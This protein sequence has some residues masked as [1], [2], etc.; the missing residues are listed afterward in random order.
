MTD[1]GDQQTKWNARYAA[2]AMQILPQ[3]ADVLLDFQH[4]LP[5][6]GVALDLACGLGGNALFLAQKGMQTHAWDFSSVAIEKLTS[7][8]ASRQVLIHAL[9]RDVVNQPPAAQDYDVIAVSRFLHRPL[10]AKIVAAL[11][12]S[13]LVFYQTF[14]QDKTS[15]IG[16]SNPEYLLAENEL[17]KLFSELRILDYREEGLVGN[18]AHGFRH[19]AMLVGQKKAK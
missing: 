6:T 16:P 9:V 18:T 12:P 3:P 19:E 15:D 7:L 4:L 5:N 8:A 10:I 1:S 2:D 14:I 11:K 13:G 17:L